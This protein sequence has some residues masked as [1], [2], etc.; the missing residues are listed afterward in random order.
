M[1]NTFVKTGCGLRADGGN[2][3]MIKLDGL[4]EYTYCDADA[5][6]EPVPLK[7]SGFTQVVTEE[8]AAR[9]D[10]GERGNVAHVLLLPNARA[11]EDLTEEHDA[12]Q[13]QFSDSDCDLELDSNAGTDSDEDE[14][15]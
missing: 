2:K 9:L 15:Q 7:R 14:Y 12:A 13:Y 6:I 11:L 5:D 10:E 3:H 8:E 4:T 1:E